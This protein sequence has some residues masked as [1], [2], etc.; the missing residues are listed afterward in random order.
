M[1]IHLTVVWCGVS[2]CL[3]GHPVASPSSQTCQ[4]QDQTHGVPLHQ[5][6]SPLSCPSVTQPSFRRHVGLNSQ[7]SVGCASFNSV[8]VSCLS[9]FN[10]YVK[11]LWLQPSFLHTGIPHFPGYD[12]LQPPGRR[13]FLKD[14]LFM[15]FSIS[16]T[17]NAWPSLNPVKV[18]ILLPSSRSVCSLAYCAQHTSSKPTR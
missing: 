8:P 6:P 13:I 12:P 16:K 10:F 11:P 7:P 5:L 9:S 3:C 4:V 15:P 18:N 17:I 2:H 14:Y 1:S